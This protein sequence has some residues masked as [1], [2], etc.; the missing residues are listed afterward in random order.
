M[1]IKMYIKDV[2]VYRQT[3]LS[4]AHKPSSQ[5]RSR[6]EAHKKHI[7]GADKNT[8]ENIKIYITKKVLKSNTQNHE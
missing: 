4:T 3:T 6:K 2:S 5:Y 7:T 8:T 1:Y